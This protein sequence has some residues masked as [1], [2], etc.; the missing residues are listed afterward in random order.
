MYVA[1]RAIRP[2][3][4]IRAEAVVPTRFGEFSMIVFNHLEPDPETGLSPDHVALVKA[5]GNAVSAL[6]GKR[7]V[8]CRVHSECLTSEVFGS[9]KCDCKDQLEAAQKEIAR[10]GEGVILYLRQEGRGIGLA[11]KIR[12]YEL[13]SE[14][15]DTVD[16]NRMLDLPDDAREYD[17]AAAM[18][19]HLGVASIRLITN[20]PL[21]VEALER[22]G[23]KVDERVSSLIHPNAFSHSY[24]EAKRQRMNHQLPHLTVVR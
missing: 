5:P 20:N 16:A 3:L 9:L 14:G 4:R 21:K 17:G 11:N 22:H 18:L 19:E 7:G 2:L 8:L 10:V 6:N 24:L 15:H 1:S 23:V 13:Q 12:A